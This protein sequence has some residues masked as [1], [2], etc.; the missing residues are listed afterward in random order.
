MV[1]G[2]QIAHETVPAVPQPWSPLLFAAMVLTG[3]LLGIWGLASAWSFLLFIFKSAKT[4]TE[5]RPTLTKSHYELLYVM[6]RNPLEPLNLDNVNY[7][8]APF[9]KLEVIQWV[10]E[11]EKNEL[12]SINLYHESLVTLTDS[13]REKALEV[14]RAASKNA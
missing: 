6:G 10:S 1:V 2:P 5:P 4:S 7:R 12:V 3:S 9:S 14:E 13:G 8:E 11:L